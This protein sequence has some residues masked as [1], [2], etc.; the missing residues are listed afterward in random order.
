MTSQP[1]LW[2][3]T[4]LAVVVAAAL[5]L[6]PQRMRPLGR[7]WQELERRPALIL[8]LLAT[9]L[10]VVHFAVEYGRP[11]RA[12]G[13]HDEFAFLLSAR[14]LMEGR[15]TN[16][17][18]PEPEAIE[19]IHILINPT[20]N[21]MYPPGF[22]LVL[23]AAW[24]WLGHPIYANWFLSPWLGLAAW[25]MLRAWLPN[26]WA[27]LGGALVAMRLGLFGYWAESYMV[28][29]LPALCGFLFGGALP[30]LLRHPG[31][32]LGLTAG[33]SLGVMFSCR[34]FEAVMLG[35]SALP[36][37]ILMKARSS[38]RAV[39]GLV[40][41]L[42][43]GASVLYYNYRL[44]GDYLRFGY[45]VNMERHGWGIFPGARTV[46]TYAGLTAHNRGFYEE[47]RN[48]QAFGFTPAGFVA[49][50]VKVIGW[51]WVFLIGPLLTV[52]FWHWRRSLMVKRLRP[53]LAGLL[54]GLGVL[55]LNPW[56]SPH[57]YA[58]VLG[59]VL[60]FLLT[61]LRM[62]VVRWGA[63]GSALAALLILSAAGVLA[64][65]TAAGNGATPAPVT[66][67]SWLP[68]NTP[69]GL[70]QR[71]AF[72]EVARREAPA[73]VLVRYGPQESVY[74]DWVYNE[75]DPTRAEIVWANDRGPMA[76]RKAAAAYPGRR[77]ICIAIEDG[78]PSRRD[79]ASWGE[80][81]GP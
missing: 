61:G 40:A 45:S 10:C 20:Y 27:L 57:Y 68:Y 29:T 66:A 74:E 43:I 21:A 70:E 44:T 55:V 71:R 5:R 17:V 78:R 15:L 3:E 81:I 75:P 28:G 50:R 59:F 72:A 56:P 63:N 42:L 11:R 33:A 58:G 9:V 30:R 34:P 23:A 12:P 38:P 31:V 22:P 24:R 51:S 64:V 8:S 36:M 4:T 53:V 49:T 52:G 14:T 48:F 73:L 26:R 25:W 41:L 60:V 77:W 32:G 79:C 80:R 65:R 46:G 67:F 13:I 54:A 16:P 19:T 76:N 1:L 35:L 7:W 6:A 39:P 18:P 62:W 47:T 37:A 2:L 69:P